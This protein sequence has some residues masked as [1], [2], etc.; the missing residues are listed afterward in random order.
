MIENAEDEGEVVSRTD[1]SG[2]R[3]VVEVPVVEVDGGAEVT[4]EGGGPA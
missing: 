2:G 4:E 1:D 3:G